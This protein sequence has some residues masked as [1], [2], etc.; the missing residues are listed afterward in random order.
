M[1]ILPLDAVISP[2][3]PAAASTPLERPPPDQT[4][5]EELP[6]A[7]KLRQHAE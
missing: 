3:E 1:A 5:I 4:P 7:G 6:F 2:G